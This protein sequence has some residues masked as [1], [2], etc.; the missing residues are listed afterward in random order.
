M[1][2]PIGVLP[3][4]AIDHSASTRPRISGGVAN[5]N[6]ALAATRK[7]TEFDALGRG[8]RAYEHERAQHDRD[9]QQQPARHVHPRRVAETDNHRA[10]SHRCGEQAV[11]SGAALERIFRE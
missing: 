7:V 9:P 2:P 11:G 5:C 1:G 8:D 4:K 6:V 3:M 10:Q